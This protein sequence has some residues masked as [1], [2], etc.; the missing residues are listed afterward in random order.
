MDR[1]RDG[2]K[3]FVPI[4]IA[5]FIRY[6]SDKGFVKSL[7]Q[8]L[9]VLLVITS[10]TTILGLRQFPMASRELAGNN[11]TA[12]AKL[13]ILMNIGGFD[14]I[15]SL[16][17]FLPIMFW[18]IRNTQKINKWLNIA[19]LIIFLY[20]IYVSNYATALLLSLIALALGLIERNT[21]SRPFFIVG[22]TV[23]LILAGTG[24]VSHALMDISNIVESEYVADRFVQLSMLLGGT[25][26]QNIHTDSNTERLELFQKAIN[27]FLN[28]PIW[29][30]NWSDFSPV[31]SG[32]SVIF[33]LLAGAGI[34]G[35]GMCIYIFYKIFRA[36]VVVEGERINP[37]TRAVWILFLLT[38]VA[39]PSGFSLVYL[40][41]FTAATCIQCL[42]N[43]VNRQYGG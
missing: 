32:H 10:I 14:F 33:D 24:V 9:V 18:L 43:S 38:S 23:I 37:Y 27:G 3:A 36:V 1:V 31:I 6:K 4:L 16:V 25:E 20:C 7:L 39:N 2:M 22:L 19:A 28:S 29:G 41:I 8:F 35:L 17:V 30:H 21:K 13:Y 5:F 12:Q 42:E 34:L 26:I 15:Y 11:E 40:M